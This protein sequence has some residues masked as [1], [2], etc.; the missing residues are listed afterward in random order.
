MKYSIQTIKNA[1]EN[2]TLD[3]LTWPH[4]VK[5]YFVI[6]YTVWEKSLPNNV[7]Q[8]YRKVDQNKFFE[9]LKDQ[10]ENEDLEL[11]DSLGQAFLFE[12]LNN[13]IT[14][15]K[16]I[17]YLCHIDAIN[18]H[19]MEEYKRELSRLHNIDEIKSIFEQYTFLNIEIFPY[20]SQSIINDFNKQ[21]E[22]IYISIEEIIDSLSD[23]LIELIKS[24]YSLLPKFS[25]I[26]KVRN[27]FPELCNLIDI[28]L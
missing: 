17:F 16:I 11:T 19:F 1:I 8:K 6:L 22:N 20:V 7:I 14:D 24:D 5:A 4:E 18:D 27:T 9:F 2:D 13:I 10:I 28:G 15:P 21:A 25:K 12:L 26:K 23:K 3:S